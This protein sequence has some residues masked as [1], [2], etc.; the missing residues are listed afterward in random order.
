MTIITHNE[1]QWIAE[2]TI[3]ISEERGQELFDSYLDRESNMRNGLLLGA[4]ENG[5]PW[6]PRENANFPD[7]IAEL[8]EDKT[9]ISADNGW[10][11]FPTYRESFHPIPTY[12]EA[13]DGVATRWPTNDITPI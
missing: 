13:V 6:T 11:T 5:R 10:W 7:E 8:V 12:D 3:F 4:E 2:E 9:G 1:N